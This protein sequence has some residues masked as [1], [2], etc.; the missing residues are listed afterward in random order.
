[1][2]KSRFYFFNALI[3]YVYLAYLSNSWV[4]FCYLF[5]IIFDSILYI[6]QNL[7][8]LSLFYFI[9]LQTSELTSLDS[10]TFKSNSFLSLF[11]S[12]PIFELFLFVMLFLN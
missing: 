2:P 7:F 4:N 11:S 3:L 10:S 12:F 8:S 1:M 6:L 5:Y 9:F